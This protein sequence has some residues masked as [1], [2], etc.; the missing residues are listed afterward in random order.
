MRSCSRTELAYW[1]LS[2]FTRRFVR[3]QGTISYPSRSSS[4]ACLSVAGLQGVSTPNSSAFA[5]P[6]T[7]NSKPHTTSPADEEYRPMPILRRYASN[8]GYVARTLS[9]DPKKISKSELKRWLKKQT[10]DSSQLE[11]FVRACKQPNFQSAV[12]IFDRTPPTSE[13]SVAHHHIPSS[14]LA[15]IASKKIQDRQQ[16]D[17][18]LVILGHRIAIEEDVMI[19]SQLLNSALQASLSVGHLVASAELVDYS[20]RYA[21]EIARVEV[22]K[23]TIEAKPGPV[24][25]PSLAIRPLISCV[26][27]LLN[28]PASQSH[29]PTC[30]F[31]AILINQII[32]LCGDLDSVFRRLSKPN[33]HLISRAIITSMFSPDGHPFKLLEMNLMLKQKLPPS[34]LRL[35]MTCMIH[36]GRQDQADR[37]ERRLLNHVNVAEAVPL[38]YQLNYALKFVRRCRERAYPSSEKLHE[39][40]FPDFPSIARRS[41]HPIKT[42]T[43]Y[44]SVLYQ[45]HLPKLALRVW[46]YVT[47]LGIRPDVAALQV[48][49][50]VLIDL[51]RPREAVYLFRQHS[52]PR[53]HTQPGSKPIVGSSTSNLQVMATY[54]R[55]LDLA[56]RHSDVYHLWKTL[57]SDWSVEPDERIFGALI[58]SA[59]KLA[60]ATSVEPTNNMLQVPSPV[61]FGDSS[62]GVQD[63]WDGQPAA[64]VAIR[65][66]WSIL[67]QN[68]PAI[69]ET[70]SA[71]LK[72]AS[73]WSGVG[74]HELLLS[75]L[76]GLSPPS[77]S[78][79]ARSRPPRFSDTLS[80]AQTVI[81]S[82]QYTLDWPMLFP[83]RYSFRDQIELL[84]I[85]DQAHYIPLLLSWMRA[86]KVKPDQDVILRSYYWIYQISSPVRERLVA[87]DVFV[88]HW[89]KEVGDEIEVV[90]PTDRMM[91]VHYLDRF[92]WKAGFFNGRTMAGDWIKRS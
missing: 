38:K 65:L 1:T 30:K 48:A 25:D 50:T 22:E 89:I 29:G 90:V 8:A 24:Q 49:M 59:R 37:C 68:W 63:D 47:H 58:S 10:F 71:P 21:S 84:G 2:V 12:A 46:E 13:D 40:I 82:L 4:S 45:H 60:I 64:E 33:V 85:C 23:Q 92:K 57:K 66:F 36:T 74:A 70:I 44:M 87:L 81:P 5:D 79:Q 53:N 80:T 51:D 19:A 11:V 73:L 7:P 32:N 43:L 27:A 76:R 56:G 26:A 78:A 91:E 17:D 34:T 88:E 3:P 67:Y 15:E 20:I 83:T 42:F 14:I 16:L 69:A 54:A 28:R 62:I 41:G 55:A 31:L 52:R 39:Q 75:R 72:T 18:L 61:P 35:A 6:S 9:E 77:N 86:L